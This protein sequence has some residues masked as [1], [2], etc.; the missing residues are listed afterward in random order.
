MLPLSGFIWGPPVSQPGSRPGVAG[1]TCAPAP[2]PLAFLRQFPRYTRMR[3]VDVVTAKQGRGEGPAGAPAV[4]LPPSPTVGVMVGPRADQLGELPLH[5][6]PAPPPLV[7]SGL[8]RRWNHVR[9][10]RG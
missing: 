4:A 10:P 9:L 3:V 1:C 2:S 5:S 6:R 7:P 8:Q